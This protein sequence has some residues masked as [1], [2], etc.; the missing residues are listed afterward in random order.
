V[1]T[2]TT[3][4]N[5]VRPANRRRWLRLGIGTVLTAALVA[6]G[7]GAMQAMAKPG[8]PET[9]LP[10]GSADTMRVRWRD[11]AATSGTYYRVRYSKSSSMSGA[12]LGGCAPI[13]PN[14]GEGWTSYH[15]VQNLAPNTPYYFQV[16]AFRNSTCTTTAGD[17][18]TR[19]DAKR[20]AAYAYGKPGTPVVNNKGSNS[21]ELS[22]VNVSGAPGYR[23]RYYSRSGGGKYAWS[24]VEDLTLTGLSR[25]TEYWIKAAVAERSSLSGQPE[26]C[27]LYSSVSCWPSFQQ[28]P[29]SSE[30][31]VRTSSYSLA[32]PTRLMISDQQA[33]QV[34]ASW[35][36]GAPLPPGHQYRVQFSTS[37]TMSN[38]RYKLAGT[39][40]ETVVTGLGS[41]T[42]YYMRVYVVRTS[43]AGNLVAASDKSGFQI[44]KTR[45]PYG[46]IAGRVTGPP[47]RD[48]QAMVFTTSGEV[49][50]QVDVDASGNFTADVRPGWYKVKLTYIGTGNF[51]STW[52][53]S[54]YSQGTPLIGWGQSFSVARS[55]TRTLP[56]TTLVPGAQF[57][58]HLRTS[59][60]ADITGADVAAI[61]AHNSAREVDSVQRSDGDGNVTI[62]GLTVPAN[63]QTTPGKY[64]LRIV[65]SGKRTT[66]VWVQVRRTGG[67]MAVTRWGLS[68]S[69]GQ[70]YS[71]NVVT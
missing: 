49:V 1:I 6:G 12:S 26:E 37:K 42:N 51:V 66:N 35:T 27:A 25:G 63:Y 43:A 3:N 52:V 60:N 50:N 2:V 9:Y 67:G 17:W 19:S 15:W 11:D 18:S 31:K 33:Y 54:K 7:F 59:S 29:Y 70:A 28:G 30:I 8:K 20:T 61:N 47:P 71:G 58:M 56:A 38:A 69:A 13:R 32:A 40:T 24:Q 46:V 48:V 45:T 22:F 44:A 34:K 65:A 5:V 39:A 55:Q 62:D 68:G 36:P 16:R 57:R 10:Q 53:N 23:I 64:W 14:P 4:E 41:N 21:L